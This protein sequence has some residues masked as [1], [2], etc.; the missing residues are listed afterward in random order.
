M[1]RVI[2]IANQKGGIGKS[3]SVIEIASVLSI[4]YNKKVLVIDLDQQ[5]NLSKYIG[6]NIE[7]DQKGHNL[8]PSIYDVLTS[9]AFTT[10]S[11]QH[12]SHF[13]AIS[14]SEQLSKADRTFMDSDDMYLLADIIDG[15]KELYD[16]IIID[17]GPSRNIL[18]T[19]SYVA[20]DEIIIPSECDEGSIDGI[21]AIYSDLKKLRE[22]RNKLSHA[23]VK[24]LILT[25]YEKTSIHSIA[26]EE[27]LAEIANRMEQDIGYR[28]FVLPVRKS[29]KMSE[30]KGFKQS[31]QEY[32][33]YGN[34]AKDYRKIVKTL[35][36]E[37]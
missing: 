24:G 11:I 13:D 3:S 37:A 17:N 36:K 14:A 7:T 20:S 23:I 9:D 32:D 12:L 6:A 10:D 28:P 15:I 4:E 25:R 5:R 1:R 16:Y 31:L 26:L 19:M 34:A 2:S 22:S 27:D 35:I 8:I 33:R 30:C 21:I 18:L 29:I